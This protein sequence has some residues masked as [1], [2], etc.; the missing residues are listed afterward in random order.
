MKYVETTVWNQARTQLMAFSKMYSNPATAS[1]IGR[2]NR[3]ISGWPSDDTVPAEGLEDVQQ[4]YNRLMVG[5][6]DVEDASNK[7]VK[8]ELVIIFGSFSKQVV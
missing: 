4:T 3:C 5:L 8:Y 7:E 2:V 6:K 1:T